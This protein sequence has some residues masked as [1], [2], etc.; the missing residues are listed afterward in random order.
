MK[1]F[2]KRLEFLFGFSNPVQ[3]EGVLLKKG[4]KIEIKMPEEFLGEQIWYITNWHCELDDLIQPGDLICTIESNSKS[5]DFESFLSGRI[6]YRNTS[7]NCL[8]KNTII[9]EIIG[10]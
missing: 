3:H 7:K 9:V 6:H 2:L 5:S 8:T 1:T 4:E 10:E